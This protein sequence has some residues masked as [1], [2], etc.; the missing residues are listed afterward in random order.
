MKLI[1]LVFLIFNSAIADEES[2]LLLEHYKSEI[3]NHLKDGDLRGARA[4]LENAKRLATET[5][6]NLRSLEQKITNVERELIKRKQERIKAEKEK[7]QMDTA[8]RMAK[9]EEA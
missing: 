6:V 3:S 2:E 8:E 7:E 1:L 4:E 5:L 9:N